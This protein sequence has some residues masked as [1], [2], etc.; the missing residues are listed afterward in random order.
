MVNIDLISKK[1]EE[2]FKNSDFNNVSMDRIAKETK[3]SKKTIYKFFSSKYELISYCCEKRMYYVEESI[4]EI[5]FNDEI[6]FK[7]K[8]RKYLLIVSKN[9]VFPKRHLDNIYSH[10]PE[11]LK[12]Y[13]NFKKKCECDYFKILLEEGYKQNQLNK[14]IETDT[15]INVFINSLKNIFVSNSDKKEENENLH[16]LFNNTFEIISKGIF[17]I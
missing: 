2:L 13:N 14:N 3:I 6:I 17:L 4:K 8:L 1:A 16:D 11:I 10:F 12:N 9:Q 15:I 5:I 7:E